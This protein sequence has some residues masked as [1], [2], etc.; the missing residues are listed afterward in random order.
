MKH[1]SVAMEKINMEKDV[2]LEHVSLLENILRETKSEK[3]ATVLALDLMLVGV[4]TVSKTFSF[5]PELYCLIVKLFSLI[6]HLSLLHQQCYNFHKI[7]INN[8]NCM[9]N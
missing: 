7:K 5:F 9:K 4:D 3:I 6:R 8:K 1:I 2:D